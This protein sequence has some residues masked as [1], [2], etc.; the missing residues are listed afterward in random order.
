MMTSKKYASVLLVIFTT[1]FLANV[2]LWNGIT[3]KIF[4]GHD[5]HGDLLRLGN[6]PYATS[7]TEQITYE[8]RHTEFK[9]YI[10]S[11]SNDSYDVLTIGDSFSNGGGGAYYQDELE[12]AYSLSVLNIPLQHRSPFEVLL[13]LDHLGYIDRIQPRIIILETVE[14]NMQSNWG[15]DL[16]LTTSMDDNFFHSLMTQPEKTATKIVGEQYFPGIMVKTNLFFL[17]NKIRFFRHPYRLTDTTNAVPLTQ[18]P[19]T[20]SGREHELIFYNDDLWYQK[21]PDDCEAINANL[22]RIAEKLHQ[23]GIQLVFLPGPN[24]FDVYYPQLTESWKEQ[25]PENPFFDQMNALPKNYIFIDSRK[26]LRE[27]VANGETDVY[28][29]DDTH[30]S[31]KAHPIVCAEI[32]RQLES[33]KQAR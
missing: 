16:S 4:T 15:K 26:L 27:A 3:G 11:N 19:F 31:W 9:D 17:Q 33:T 2:L 23:R 25:W 30:W 22:N 29:S 12:S 8:K 28:W 5:E 10:E 1:F 18:N 20:A 14:R 32:M 24:K 13:T 6:L 7:K 21:H